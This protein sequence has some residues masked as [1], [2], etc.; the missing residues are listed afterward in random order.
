MCLADLKLFD[1]DGKYDVKLDQS[2]TKDVGDD[3]SP[4]RGLFPFPLRSDTRYSSKVSSTSLRQFPPH[5]RLPE[6]DICFR[7]VSG[8]AMP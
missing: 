1:V 7:Q 2:E 6:K 4:L 8:V 3:P 5:E